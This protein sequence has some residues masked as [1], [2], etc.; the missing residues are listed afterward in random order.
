MKKTKTD[1]AKATELKL[2]EIQKVEVERL[3]ASLIRLHQ[4][5]TRA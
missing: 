5:H 3:R 4:L 2:R 1:D